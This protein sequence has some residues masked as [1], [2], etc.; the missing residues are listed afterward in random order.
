[1]AKTLF[2]AFATVTLI[3]VVTRLMAFLFKVYLSRKL[4]AEMLG[5]Y[6]I[7]MSVFMLFIC[8]AASG[9]PTTLS[10]K[11]AEYDALGNIGKTNSIFT[12]S[13][14]ISV[15]MSLIICLFFTLFPGILKFLFADSRCIELF[16]ILMPSLLSTGIYCTARA[17]FWGKGKF[18]AYGLTE[19]FEEIVK[20]AVTSTLIALPLMHGNLAKGVAVAYVIGD[21]IAAGFVLLLYIVLN[22]KMAR[23]RYFKEVAKSAAPLTGTRIYGS[24]LSS[25]A[26]LLLPVLLIK[27][28]LNT[29]EAT[30]EFGRMSGMAMPLLLTPITIIGSLAVV[31][32]PELAK[33]NK[34]YVKVNRQ[35]TKA[36]IFATYVAAF[37]MVIFYAGG[38]DIGIM[39]Y[40]DARSG[41]F[42]MNSTALIIPLALSQLSSTMLNSLGKETWTFCVNIISSVVLLLCI[43]LLPQF[44]GIM[45]YPIGLFFFHLSGLL[46]DTIKIRKLTKINLNYLI[47]ECCIVF[48]AVGAAAA[49]RAISSTM[50]DLFYFWRLAIT[51]FSGS[52]IFSISL[53][54]ILYKYIK[55]KKSKADNSAL[56]QPTVVRKE[57]V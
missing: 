4:G 50:P 35:I 30:A 45:A 20:I 36:S 54:P 46:L 14:V 18:G 38:E 43:F 22:G 25:A 31:I 39:L 53:L 41:M 24:L 16:I 57:G 11:T 42:L 15:G 23:P 13:M 8:M 21:F 3:S 26:A 2:K 52:L 47:Y 33:N 44:V 49:A 56:Y 7:T 12:M 28:G 5:V 51:V 17:W 29:S 37:F 9:I 10:R 32:V 27:S 55:D 34:D 40:G 48:M 19:L 6:Q 1:M